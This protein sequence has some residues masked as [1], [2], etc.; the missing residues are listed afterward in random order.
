MNSKFIKKGIIIAAIA[1][2]ILIPTGQALAADASSFLNLTKQ[3]KEV[4]QNAL[5]NAVAEI[6]DNTNTAKTIKIESADEIKLSDMLSGKAFAA[7]GGEGYLIVRS[8]ADENS[9][10]IGK[11]YEDSVIKVIGRND[12]WTKIS[13]GN[14]EGF[15]KTENLISGKAAIEKAKALLTGMYPETDLTTLNKEVIDSSFS[16]GETNQEEVT[17]LAEEEAQRIAEEEARIAAEQARI[18]AEEAARQAELQARG[19]AVVDYAKQFLGNPYVYGG[20]SLTNGT[21]CSGF[22]RAI[23]AHFGISMP[24]SSYYMRNSGY[25]VSYSEMM[26]GDVVCYSGH[27]GIYAGNGKI[28]N[29]IDESRGIGMSN[30]NYTKIIT[31][32][33]MY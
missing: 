24:R 27:V 25:E 2:T 9:E 3:S 21:D 23:Y 32:R 28:V 15:I 29:A 12:A 5:I 18:A 31:I 13:S 16:V 8:T 17:R 20:T 30:V 6:N 14:V 7:V 26:P 22:V 10:S 1:S 33:R 4:D 19:Q 11:V